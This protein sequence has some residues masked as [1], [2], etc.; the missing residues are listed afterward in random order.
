MLQK[1]SVAYAFP[2]YFTRG[3]FQPDNPILAQV[4]AGPGEPGPHRM[5]AFL[6]GGV[7][8]AFPGLP[9]EVAAYARA[10][11]EVLTLVE[12]PRRVPGGEAIKNDLAGLQGLVDA[13][14]DQ[15]MCR[16]SV[17]LA[18]G[19]GAVLDAVGFAAALVHRGLRLVRVPTTV[20]AQGDSGVGVKNA[21][22][23]RGAKNLLGTFAPPLAVLNDL[24][25]LSGLPDAAWTDGIAEAFKVA[26]IKDRPFFDWLCA[27]AAALR[28]RD[29]AAMENLV[30]RCAE[31]HLRHIAEGGDPF[32]FGQARP[33]DFGHWAAHRLE[34]LSGFALSH[35][36]AVAI[37]LVLDAWY[38]VLNRWLDVPSFEALFQGL[39]EAGFDLWHEALEQ[40][41]EEGV[42]LLLHGLH[43][44]R[45]HLG[46]RLSVTMPRGLGARFEV[47]EMNHDQI[48]A[49]VRKLREKAAHRL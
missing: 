29:G 32:E 36:K 19:G 40:T 10:H 4:V 16:H 34:Q 14:V 22:N 9:G 18:V 35:G 43:E 15:R 5:L 1:F 20:L 7:V 47:H 8:E 42:L 6:D 45:E 41:G 49:A 13:L 24:D 37:G 11:A 23:Y 3:L 12:P 30:R 28:A 39:S 2:V 44:F 26:V 21:V 25:F 33:L 17:V 31:L 38:A 27:H 48:H 46:G